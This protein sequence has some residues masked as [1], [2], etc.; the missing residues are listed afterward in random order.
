[1]AVARHAASGPIGQEF[2]LARTNRI[3]GWQ[4]AASNPC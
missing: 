3:A 4:H 2:V 1:M